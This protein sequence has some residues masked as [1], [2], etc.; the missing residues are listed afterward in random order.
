MPDLRVRR[1]TPTEFEVEIRSATPNFEAYVVRLNGAEPRAC[2]DG[3]LRWK[4]EPGA[5]S[6][7]V[8]SRNLFGVDGPR[9]N[10]S[11]AFKP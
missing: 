9:V 1:A 5:N 4:L 10:V 6:L 7:Q 3:R 11:V 2:A 8:H